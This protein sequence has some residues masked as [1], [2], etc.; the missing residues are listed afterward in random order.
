VD[1]L[2]AAE[3]ACGHVDYSL[4]ASS[5]SPIAIQAKALEVT[6]NLP[7]R[8]DGPCGTI[9]AI[10]RSGERRRRLPS[11]SLRPS[12]GQARELRTRKRGTEFD[13]SKPLYRDACHPVSGPRSRPIRRRMLPSS[14]TMPPICRALAFR[15]EPPRRGADR[16]RS[17]QRRPVWRTAV[18]SNEALWERPLPE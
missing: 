11:R 4:N 9:D 5:P 2:P 18:F 7:V 14:R 13:L 17:R 6:D 16:A 12:G 8:W 3:A 10:I 15:P 1:R